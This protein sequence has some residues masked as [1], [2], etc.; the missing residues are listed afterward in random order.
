MNSIIEEAIKE[1]RLIFFKNGKYKYKPSKK[2]FE[3][4]NKIEER[5]SLR[6]ESSGTFGALKKL[7]KL[8][9]G[10]QYSQKTGKRFIGVS[11]NKFVF[12]EV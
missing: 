3:S 6:I 11:E 7:E 2:W 10:F 9:K 4:K 5:S 12:S 8:D 1:G